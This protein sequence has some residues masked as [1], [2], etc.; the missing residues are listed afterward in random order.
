MTVTA[1]RTEQTFRTVMS[2]GAIWTVPPFLSLTARLAEERQ[3]DAY[4]FRR[5]RRGLALTRSEDGVV[6]AW[7]KPS[8][9][10]HHHSVFHR[11]KVWDVAV[12]HSRLGSGQRFRRGR[13]TGDMGVA[14]IES[15]YLHYVSDWRNHRRL[16]RGW[17]EGSLTVEGDVPAP[18]LLLALRLVL[19]REWFEVHT[20]DWVVTRREC[21]FGGF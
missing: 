20:G 15:S 19:G 1:Q 12:E 11:G 16:H 6:I 4:R 5:K 7:S 14:A 10:A 13:M 18:A 8:S 17:V 2:D 9:R 21:D 3:G